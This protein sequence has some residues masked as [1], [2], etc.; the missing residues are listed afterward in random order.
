MREVNC[1]EKVFDF[2]ERL[3][4]FDP[5]FRMSLTEGLGHP[6]L[7]PTH[8]PWRVPSHLLSSEEYEEYESQGSQGQGQV[9]QA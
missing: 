4:R 9:M 2:V 6:W 3:L 8:W 1:S 7:H 5:S